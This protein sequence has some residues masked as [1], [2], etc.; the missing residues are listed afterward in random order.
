MSGLKSSS[1]YRGRMVMRSVSNVLHKSRR[2][3]CILLAVLPSTNVCISVAWSAEPAGVTVDSQVLRVQPQLPRLS[4]QIWFRLVHNKGAKFGLNAYAKRIF[5]TS[6]GH[7]YV[8]VDQERAAIR[9]VQQTAVGQRLAKRFAVYSTAVMPYNH[10][11]SAP[12]IATPSITRRP[13]RSHTPRRR[14]TRALS[15]LRRPF[16]TSRANLRGTARHPRKRI[17]QDNWRAGVRQDLAA[18]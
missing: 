11:A 17:P 12:A 2:T 13:A 10:R 18:P 9:A 15:G 7:Y 5:V 4:D 16:A 1:L 6:T 8:P 3:A 14:Q